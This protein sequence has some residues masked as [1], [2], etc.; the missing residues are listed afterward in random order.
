[1]ERIVFFSPNKLSAQEEQE[2]LT[3]LG[4]TFPNELND[5]RTNFLEKQ[6]DAYLKRELAKYE[7]DYRASL[8]HLRERLGWL[9]KIKTQVNADPQ[10]DRAKIERLSGCERE[11]HN[12]ASTY[13][14]NMNHL[15]FLF[16]LLER[17]RQAAE[18]AIAQAAVPGAAVKREGSAKKEEK[19]PP[20]PKEE[21]GPPLPKKPKAELSAIIIYG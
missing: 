13:Y 18:A 11:I 16:S 20:L 4:Y 7:E 1:M 3:A 15:E 2:L 19:G 21:K 6:S 10:L 8:W 9:R 12:P 5:L 17:R 14:H